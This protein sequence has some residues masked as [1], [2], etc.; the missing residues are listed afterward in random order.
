VPSLILDL[1]FLVTL[2]QGAVRKWLAP[3]LSLEIEFFRDM[4]P[5]LALI[6]SYGRADIR[7]QMGRFT[8]RTLT[9][10][11]AYASVAAFEA[12]SPSLPV[13][14]VLVGIRTHFAYLPLAF[15][16]PT[17]LKSWAHGLRKFRQLLVLAV[18]I[19]LLAFFQT[20]QP[21]GSV[22]NQ[23]ADPTM[24]VATFGVVD[25]VRATGTFSYIS[26]FASFA[27]ICAV[28]PLF[29]ILVSNNK[30]ITNNKFIARL[31]NIGILIMALG[32]IMASGSRAPAAMFGAQVLGIV[33]IGCGVRAIPM[34]HLFSLLAITLLTLAVTVTVLN[35][36]ATDFL[37]RAQAT[38]GDIGQRLDSGLFEWL[39][40]MAQYPLG[41]GLGAGHQAVAVNML[42]T[43]TPNLWEAELS[44]LAFE[45]GIGVVLYLAF[46]VALIGQLLARVKTMR[47]RA[48][49]TTLATC[50][51]IL[52]PLLVTASVYQA[53]TNAAFWAFVGVGLWIV[54]LEAATLPGRPVTASVLI[55]TAP[56]TR[57]PGSL[58]EE[59]V[60]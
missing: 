45:L 42:A 15:L 47:S 29:L 4:L 41:V 48:G 20:T 14:V 50:A 3:G 9:L 22:W 33:A 59:G 54:K 49:R 53:L 1:F 5:V 39:D 27:E 16:M 11:W 23:Y 8:G 17:Y 2:V 6:I 24:D 55:Q 43:E 46:K 18:P 60:R 34:R 44:R 28:I 31:L 57:R 32:A 52:I 30:F 13:F 36:Q 35:D 37:S 10:F 51:I 26:E 25:R 38:N 12:C 7:R 58:V 19:F 21:A 56:V 40:V